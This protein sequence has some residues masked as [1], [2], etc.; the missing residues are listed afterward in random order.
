MT[1]PLHRH[2]GRR[3]RATTFALAVVAALTLAP[4]AASFADDIEGTNDSTTIDGTPFDDNISGDENVLD[5]VA[6]ANGGDDTINGHEGEDDISGDGNAFGLV[7]TV[8]GGDDT[9]DGGDDD[10]NLVGDGDAGGVGGA[11]VNGGDDVIHGGAGNDD[12]VGDGSAAALGG[13]FVDGGDDI[14]YGDSGD[15]SIW[16][17]G[18]ADALFGPE[19]VDGGN[20]QLFGGFGEDR[21][22]GQGGNDILCG[23]DGH[24]ANPEDDLLIGGS[25]DDLACAVDD[26]IDAPAGE[27]VA[28][29]LADNDEF[30]DDG[31]DELRRGLPLLYLLQSIGA[32]ITVLD[33]DE[34]TG[35]LSFSAACDAGDITYG[36]TRQD[37]ENAP[38]VQAIDI[39]STATLFVNADAC[40]PPPPA[41]GDEPT[42]EPT[43]DDVED[44]AVLPDTGASGGLN[45]IGASGLGLLV[46]GIVVIVAATRRKVTA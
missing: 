23:L 11:Q 41:D 33:F 27:V 29:A 43:T 32:G 25:G 9:I 2:T 45:A 28:I 12:I 46:G 26:E 6:E 1:S 24:Q 5:F 35:D 8:N 40:P 38:G 19:D 18:F 14:L 16:G 4:A 36:V 37:D 21:L 13:A 34:N 30:L 3:L 42:A 15:D 20:D 22:F 39:M 17:D 7:A 44:T 10:D 31:D